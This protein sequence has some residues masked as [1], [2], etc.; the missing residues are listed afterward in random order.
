[1]LSPNAERAAPALA[2]SGSLK[3]D[4]RGAAIERDIKQE[5][6]LGQL[7]DK[8]GHVRSEAIFKNWTPAAILM[9]DNTE[10]KLRNLVPYK[11]GQ[12]EG[13]KPTRLFEGRRL[14]RAEADGN[15]HLRPRRPEYLGG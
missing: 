5:P 13:R 8:H 15:R 3:I 1:M 9:V 4:R 2:D 14:A 10:K 6:R 12:S 7:I 11:P